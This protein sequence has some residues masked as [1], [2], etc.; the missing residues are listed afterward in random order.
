MRPEWPTQAEAAAV[1]AGCDRKPTMTELLR[2]RRRAGRRQGW[3]EGVV[4]GAVLV[5]LL[6]GLR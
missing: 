3:L 5:L 6:M 1:L 2:E 4:A